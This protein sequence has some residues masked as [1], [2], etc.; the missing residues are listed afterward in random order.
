MK[1]D[2]ITITD[3]VESVYEVISEYTD[4]VV[5]SAKA[6]SITGTVF[7]TEILPELYNK[8]R[9]FN[10]KERMNKDQAA[11]SAA[12]LLTQLSERDHMTMGNNDAES[13]LRAMLW[14]CGITVSVIKG[15][16]LGDRK[17]QTDTVD[18]LV[19]MVL[20]L[21]TDE[22]GRFCIPDKALFGR[23][24]NSFEN[25][26]EGDEEKAACD[27]HDKILEIE[28]ENGDIYKTI[29]NKALRS[30]SHPIDSGI[31][32]LLDRPIVNNAFKS[33]VDFLVDG[34]YGQILAS[35]I[36]VTEKN[37]P[38]LNAIVDECAQTLNIRRPYVVVSQAIPGINAATFGSD[39][40]PYI[41]ISALMVRLMN[42]D[43]MRFIIG[44]ECGHIAM[45]H[46]VY[47]TVVN[48]IRL[49]GYS[50]PAVGNLVYKAV[51][52]PLHAWH[53][54]SEI[55]ADRAGLLCCHDLENA[56]RT[57]LQLESGFNDVEGIDLEEYLKNSRE[58]LKG[59]W[60]RRIGEFKASHPLIPK[61]ILALT[62]FAH[63]KQYF[64]LC[65]REIREE[66]AE[67]LLDADRLANET[68]AILK[69]M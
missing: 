4:E 8:I 16:T 11:A 38:Q 26:P 2:I 17:A 51:E 7:R 33:Y 50:I 32:S 63:S 34:T 14:R 5:E 66:D 53:R 35:A 6:N 59:S 60:V 37:Y 49:F 13:V 42:E 19:Q 43:K 45:G 36:P 68:E 58:F 69:V 30:Y 52:Y 48:T 57:L 24:L 56:Q 28:L 29:S 10:G 39:E 55:T 23:F 15:R 1:N 3:P 46:M 61:R 21:T 22:N 12:C 40:K 41:A 31:I 65:D 44:H 54:R 18:H 47:H 25:I 9:V 27:M 67:A 64:D 62:L 20:V